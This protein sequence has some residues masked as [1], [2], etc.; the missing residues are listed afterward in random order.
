[1]PN[2]NKKSFPL[3]H[4]SEGDSPFKEIWLSKE[5]AERLG[6]KMNQVRKKN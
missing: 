1:M 3:D 4:F 5:D 6:V 2:F